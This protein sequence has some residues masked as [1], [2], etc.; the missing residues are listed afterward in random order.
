MANALN[1]E[2]Q[3]VKSFME[4]I[5]IP[6]LHEILQ[7][8][9]PDKYQLYQ[10]A[11]CRQTATMGYFFLKE[12]L[13]NYEWEVWEADFKDKVMDR[14][15]KYEHAWI[16]GK[17]KS[18]K[19]KDLFVDLA[20]NH[21]ERLFIKTNKNQ[22]PANHPEYENTVILQKKRMNPNKNLQIVEFYTEELGE[23]LLREI[24]FRCGVKTLSM[25]IEGEF[26]KA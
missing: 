24:E 22:Y 4:S 26:L 16:Y 5:F 2:E 10:G 15:V 14:E 17:S 20:R 23:K 8:K 3:Q 18:R 19:E 7:A 11:A 9:S 12:L 1:L 13:P 6:S 21:Q 25:A